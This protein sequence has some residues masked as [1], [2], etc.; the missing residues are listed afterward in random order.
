MT[1]TMLKDNTS[2]ADPAVGMPRWKRYF[3][4]LV[5]AEISAT[6]RYYDRLIQLQPLKYDQ[7]YLLEQVETP[8]KEA[9]DNV[10]A[11]PDLSDEKDARTMVLLNGN[12]NFSHN[13][14]VM[15]AD[16]K[17]KLSRTSRVAVVVY[18]PYWSWIYKLASK[19]GLRDGKA[20]TT[21]VTQHDLNVICRLAGFEVVRMRPSGYLPAGLFG[22]GTLINRLLPTIPVL[23]WIGYVGVVVL[24]PIIP[25]K[26]TPSVSI[27]IPA[28]NE[29]GNIEDALRRLPDLR[30]AEIEVIFVEGNSSDDTWAEIQRVLPLYKDRYR[31]AAYQQPG[32]GK[33]DAVRVGFANATADLLVILD[34]DLT[35]PPEMLTW[36]YDAYTSGL[37]DFINGNRL[38]YQMEGEAMRFLNTLGNTFFA[39]ALSNVL[40]VRIGDSLCG[41]KVLSRVDYDRVVAWR[42]DFGDFDPFG[43]FELLFAA[44]ELCLGVVDVPIRYAARTYGS[45]NINRFQDGWLLLKMTLT[46]LFRMKSGKAS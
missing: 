17:A 1:D 7:G 4:R 44:S 25:D 29:K 5:G 6:S 14:Q 11:M 9:Y 24:R 8:S 45:T 41:T 31:L 28:R 26:G 19:L 36:F 33:N 43:D 37:G 40:G 10:E 39:K 16:I 46:G 23:K 3:Y 34:A 20:P 21:F 38:L 15:L 35:M 18:N 13:L 30:G 42:G 27:V 2:G 12:F 32:K 22:L